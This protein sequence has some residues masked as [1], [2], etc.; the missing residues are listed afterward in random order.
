MPT[1]IRAM[2]GL[3]E[4]FFTIDETEFFSPL[5]L[6][7]EE[8]A[9]EAEKTIF[10]LLKEV[11]NPLLRGLATSAMVSDWRISK[12]KFVLGGKKGLEKYVEGGQKDY[13]RWI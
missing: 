4:L 6:T 11:K 1:V 9:Q 12:W 8:A 13:S 10:A 7:M 2:T 3:E 5:S